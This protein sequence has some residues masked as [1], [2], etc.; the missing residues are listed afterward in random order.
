MKKITIK[1]KD[2]LLANEALIKLYDMHMSAMLAFKLSRIIRSINPHAESF[3]QV[4]EKSIKQYM[5]ESKR[6]SDEDTIKL[7]KDISILVDQEI[8]IEIP[9]LSIQDLIQSGLQLTPSVFDRL[10]LILTE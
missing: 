9:D 7:N 2:A 6:M 4:R 8:S 3:Q 5:G 1:L 10:A